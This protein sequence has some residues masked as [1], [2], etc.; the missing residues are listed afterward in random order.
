M[1]YKYGLNLPMRPGGWGGGLM[2]WYNIRR[3][4]KLVPLAEA[5]PTG[6]MERCWLSGLEPVQTRDNGRQNVLLLV[7]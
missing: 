5:G 1:L 4:M 6:V 3:N 7:Q 2:D